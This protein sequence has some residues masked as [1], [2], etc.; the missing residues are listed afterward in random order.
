[1]G[2]MRVWRK[3]EFDDADDDDERADRAWA[4]P[5]RRGILHPQNSAPCDDPRDAAE[6]YAEYCHA[7]RDG[8]EWSWPVDFVVHDGERYY[9]VEV[10]RETVPE[11]CASKPKDLVLDSA[12]PQSP[13]PPEA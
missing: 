11:F 10:E 1:M 7:R 3:D 6:Q 8:W 4:V 5:D 9:V 13:P 12:T 2:K